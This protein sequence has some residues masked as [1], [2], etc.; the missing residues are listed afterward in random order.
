MKRFL[1]VSIIL[2]LSILTGFKF[3]KN[4]EIKM[5]RINLNS[6]SFKE[7]EVIP[8]KYTCDGKNISPAL[9]WDKPSEEVKRFVIIME[10]PDAPGGNFVHWIVYN[11]PGN[12]THFPEDVTPIKNI[13]D[14]V[15][16]GTNGFGHIG[17]GGP[18]PPSG[19]HRYFIR[20]Y[21][22]NNALH[23]EA[24]AEKAELIRAMDK[25]IVAEGVLM[26]KYSRGR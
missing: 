17:Y 18:C 12:V 11:I 9:N 7:G 22:L 20:I 3:I 23:L 16:L 26:G 19:T 24:G 1:L 13:P 2:L 15:L 8:S 5:E 21:G 10:D 25:H 14:E 6:S 4:Q